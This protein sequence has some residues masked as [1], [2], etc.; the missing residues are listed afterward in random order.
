MGTRLPAERGHRPRV[1]GFLFA[2]IRAAGP[3]D[4]LRRVGSEAQAAHRVVDLWC[5][6]LGEIAEFPRTELAGPD[7]EPTFAAGEKGHAFAVARDGHA[8]RH[9]FEVRDA[10][11][12]G[13]G[14][15][16]TPEVV[17]VLEK[18]ERGDD[19]DHDD[20]QACCE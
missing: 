4:Y 3:D 20:D 18:P 19:S 16:I 1:D 5:P 9:A 15:W 7:I 17:G 13:V 12:T 14:Q 11:E 6:A 8:W 2:R 10:R